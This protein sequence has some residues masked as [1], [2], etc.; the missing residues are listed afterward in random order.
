M[1][2]PFFRSFQFFRQALGNGRMLPAGHRP[3]KGTKVREADMLLIEDDLF[4]LS[5]YWRRALV[6]ALSHP[7]SRQARQAINN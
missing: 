7:P 5:F 4:V 2:D 6:Q 3:E 1:G